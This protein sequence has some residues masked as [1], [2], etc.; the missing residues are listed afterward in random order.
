MNDKEFTVK[1][2]LLDLE[3]SEKLSRGIT[4]I[5]IALGAFIS[6]SLSIIN[7]S[8]LVAVV[9]ASLVALIFLADGISKLSDCKKIR[10]EI[11]KL[12]EIHPAK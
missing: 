12:S 6:V 9:V 1:K 5:S 8:L 3:H 4:E 11:K 10:G 2:N 7:K